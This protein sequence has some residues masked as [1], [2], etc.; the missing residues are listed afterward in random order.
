MLFSS[1]WRRIFG[2]F[3]NP[4][5]RRGACSCKWLGAAAARWFLV[6]EGSGRTSGHIRYITGSYAARTHTAAGRVR[7]ACGRAEPYVKTLDGHFRG[8][9]EASS[10]KRKNTPPLKIKTLRKG[11]FYFTPRKTRSS[12]KPKI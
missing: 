11:G 10:N 3:K 4:P 2:R 5:P 8:T 7:A 9:P 12:E 6:I 1:S